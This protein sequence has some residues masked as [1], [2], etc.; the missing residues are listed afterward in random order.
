MEVGAG[1]PLTSVYMLN[2]FKSYWLH[3]SDQNWEL[4][5]DGQLL[6]GD[7]VCHH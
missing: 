1:Q 2:L 6:E 3:T 5:E 4:L 7:K